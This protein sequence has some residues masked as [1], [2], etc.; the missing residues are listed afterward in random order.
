LLGE[1]SFLVFF[2]Q[3]KNRERDSITF[4]DTFRNFLERR[5][6]SLSFPLFG[7]SLLSKKFFSFS[8]SKVGE[9]PKEILIREYA[10]MEKEK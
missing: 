1:K 4:L 5:D 6:F 10:L 9:S 8:K 3:G 2:F 7:Y